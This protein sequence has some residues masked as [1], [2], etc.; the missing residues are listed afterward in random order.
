M[1]CRQWTYETSSLCLKGSFQLV[2]VK[3][4]F[5]C[6]FFP[7]FP[8][9]TSWSDLPLGCNKYILFEEFLGTPVR[10]VA[11]CLTVP[12]SMTWFSKALIAEVKYFPKDLTSDLIDHG[13][14]WI[15]CGW[16]VCLIYIFSCRMAR[17]PPPCL[18]ADVFRRSSGRTP[19]PPCITRHASSSS[20]SSNGRA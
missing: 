14:S 4:R 16:F 9:F 13:I 15:Q 10:S 19:P 7:L 8:I 1:S 12:L 17:V 3:A 2:K 11:L 6:N 20:R 5:I 18:T